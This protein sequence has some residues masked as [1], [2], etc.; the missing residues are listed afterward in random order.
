MLPITNL[1]ALPKA[2]GIYKVVDSVGNVIYIGQ[3]KD[4]HARWNDGHHKLS[5]ILAEYGATA[6]IQWVLLPEW[7]L[8]R[9]E[10]AAIRFYQPKLN[11]KM[12]PIV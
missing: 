12:P 6:F 10:S 8:N 2:S 11:I 3:A 7:L 9:A 4:I 5:A 1:K